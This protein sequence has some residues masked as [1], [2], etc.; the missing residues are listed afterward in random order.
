MKPANDLY[1]ALERAD[2]LMSDNDIRKVYRNASKMASTIRIMA[3][4]ADESRDIA[5]THAAIDV[6]QTYAGLLDETL[7]DLDSIICAV[8]NVVRAGLQEPEA[9]EDEP[10]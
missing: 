1:K 3:E 9:E 6:I 8:R 4:H 7:D 2:S 10:I 5:F